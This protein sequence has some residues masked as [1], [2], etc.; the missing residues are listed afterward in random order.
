[1]REILAVET[2]E[3]TKGII[4]SPSLIDGAWNWLMTF[5][6]GSALAE[7]ISQEEHVP[8]GLY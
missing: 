8:Q 7:V 5:G 2:S 1:M 6:V 3:V 4:S